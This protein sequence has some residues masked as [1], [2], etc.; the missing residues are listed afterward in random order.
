MPIGYPL[1]TI[2]AA[3]AVAKNGCNGCTSCD[4]VE[5]PPEGIEFRANNVFVKQMFIAKRD[6]LIPQHAHVYDHLSML[7]TGSVR[8]WKD[9]VLDRDYDAPAGIFIAAG[10]K[11]TFQSL[12]DRTIIYCVHAVAGD[13]DVEIAEEHQ[14]EGVA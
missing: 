10:I 5:Q 3:A 11:H 7:A 4:G 12:E 9:G 1:A 6:T 8:V 14:F 13:G 2:N